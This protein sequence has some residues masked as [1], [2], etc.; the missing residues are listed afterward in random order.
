MLVVI[1]R[2]LFPGLWWTPQGSSSPSGSG[3]KLH[4]RKYIIAL[5]HILCLQIYTMLALALTEIQNY[6]LKEIKTL[7]N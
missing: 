1:F 4:M 3:P 5:T 2:Q 7:F 6:G